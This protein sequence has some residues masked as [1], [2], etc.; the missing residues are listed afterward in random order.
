LSDY[1]FYERHDHDP[2]FSS[3]VVGLCGGVFCDLR[4]CPTPS[5][6]LPQMPAGSGGNACHTK[7]RTY[8]TPLSLVYDKLGL[9]SK[10][11]FSNIEILPA[12]PAVD[13]LFFEK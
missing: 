5:L 10:R 3:F 7:F 2:G 6:G 11:E 1:Y 12:N 8:V 9:G 4:D 13:H